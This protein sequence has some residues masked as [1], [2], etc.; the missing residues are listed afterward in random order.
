[1][2]FSIQTVSVSNS[3]SS[4]ALPLQQLAKAE[5]MQHMVNSTGKEMVKRMERHVRAMSYPEQPSPKQ[6]YRKTPFASA[7]ERKNGRRKRVR[8]CCIVVYGLGKCWTGE[9]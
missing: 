5:T 7:E 1:M 3:C 6:R 9:N 2:V 8:I 4:F